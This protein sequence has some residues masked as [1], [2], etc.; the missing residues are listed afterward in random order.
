LFNTGN[1][2]LLK[3]KRKERNVHG[4]SNI[5]L[6]IYLFIYSFIVGFGVIMV[7]MQRG[8]G[9][10]RKPVLDGNS[11]IYL[12]IYLFIHC[13]F[14]GDNGDYAKRVR[15]TQETGFRDSSVAI[16]YIFYSFVAPGRSSGSWSSGVFVSQRQRERGTATQ[17]RTRK[18]S[19]SSL[20]IFA[21][22]FLHARGSCMR[23]FIAM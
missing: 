22:F 10:H 6:F 18:R 13:R 12:F 1:F 9:V 2:L 4:N 11:N 21:L 15:S 5:Y 16:F 14:W 7:I 8:C 19:Q 23:A 17:A 20:Q 3:K